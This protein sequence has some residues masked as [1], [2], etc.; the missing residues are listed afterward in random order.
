MSLLSAS[1]SSL[2]YTT[3]STVYLYSQAIKIKK[4]QRNIF[5]KQRLVWSLKREE[6]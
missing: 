3:R 1:S 2:M 4:F 6:L 5:S